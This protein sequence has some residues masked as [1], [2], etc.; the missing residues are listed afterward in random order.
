MQAKQE[1]MQLGIGEKFLLSYMVIYA[2]APILANYTAKNFRPILVAAVTTL[3]TAI[4]LFFIL[5]ATRRLREIFNAK[6]FGPIFG[7]TMF[8][9]VVP[10]ALIFVG[11]SKTSAINTTLLHQTELFFAFLISGLFYGET[12]TRQKI[13]GGTIVLLG[14]IAVL[15]NGTFELRLG[16]LLIIAGTALY[17]FG[18][19]Y[20]KQALLLAQPSIVL[21][22]RTIIGGIMLLVISFI[23]EGWP[24]EAFLAKAF[25]AID[26]KQLALFAG[27]IL[28]LLGIA[29]LLWFEGL[30]RLDVSKSTAIVIAGPAFSLVYAVALLHEIPTLYQLAGMLI[31]IAGLFILIKQKVETPASSPL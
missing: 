8:N 19:H 7:N 22:L 4:A 5:A 26:Q 13:V 3:I 16:D 24:Q 17:P 20:A 28:G 9:I 11:T 6:A 14:T 27:L 18:N 30:K 21:F 31:I 12:I 23:L 2:L 10:L 25:L 29:K 1:K 15:Y